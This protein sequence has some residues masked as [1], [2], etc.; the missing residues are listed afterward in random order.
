MVSL[1]NNKDTMMVFLDK[2]II[3][4]KGPILI[5]GIL[6]YLNIEEQGLWYT[7][8]SLSALSG[9]AEMG[10]TTIISQFVSHEHANLE[11]KNGYLYGKRKSLDKAF[12]LVRYAIRVYFFIVPL[13]IF[14]LIIVGYFF[15]REQG[16]AILIAWFGYCI[17]SGLNLVASL[18]QSIYRGFDRVFQTH[19]IKAIS[20]VISIIA[21][22]ISLSLGAGLFSLPI[23]MAVLLLSTLIL[24]FNI[25]KIFWMQ[26]IRHRIKYVHSWYSEII[27]LQSKFS[28][29]FFCGY[30]MFNLFVPLAFKYQGA[31]IAGQLGLTLT[32][33]RTISAFSYTWLESKLPSMNMLAAKMQRDALNQFF[34]KKTK[35]SIVTFLS[36]S[37]V[38]LII[39]TLINKYSFYEYRVLDFKT[40]LF[41]ILSETSIVIMSIYAIF[42]R[43]HK[44]EPFHYASLISA[45]SVS[46]ISFYFMT[47]SNVYNLY[48]ALTFFHWFIMLPMFMLLGYQAMKRYYLL[49]DQELEFRQ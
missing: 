41:V 49:N 6:F 36:G 47:V 20:N 46:C 2:L 45:L 11:N 18:L 19:L 32:I 22:F 25:D 44:I 43:A 14:T 9:L 8:I 27:S 31:V 17:L 28:V 40:I 34:W 42:V 12:G 15:F 4:G 35:L 33:V 5:V 23:S 1:L 21:L 26:L 13:A 39:I 30:F 16:F 3:A 7:F 10:F 38:L 29:S 48:I 37:I 24:L